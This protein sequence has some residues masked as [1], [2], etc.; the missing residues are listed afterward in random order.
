MNTY[1]GSAEE[2][3]KTYSG[4]N[5]FNAAPDGGTTGGAT[6]DPDRLGKQPANP[7]RPS[8]RSAKRKTRGPSV[9]SKRLAAAIHQLNRD[10]GLRGSHGIAEVV[11]GDLIKN[12]K[13]GEYSVITEGWI[14]DDPEAA[15][16]TL[17]AFAGKEAA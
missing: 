6:T 8:P 17:K 15:L 9:L 13:E 2:Q 10:L 11:M 16:A 3:I 7:K 5:K 4:V 14:F 12:V 1:V